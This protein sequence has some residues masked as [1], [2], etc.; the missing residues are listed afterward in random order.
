MI[1]FRSGI[2]LGVILVLGV[3]FWFIIRSFMKREET[4]RST[5]ELTQKK[6]DLQTSRLGMLIKALSSSSKQPQR[7]LTMQPWKTFFLDEAKSLLKAE[8][9]VI[10]LEPKRTKVGKKTF[11]RRGQLPQTVEN[12]LLKATKSHG[13]FWSLPQIRMDYDLIVVSLVVEFAVGFF[14]FTRKSDE[15]FSQEN[16]S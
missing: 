6:L 8:E 14:Q 12:I 5:L 11:S 7:S 10:P 15:A 2:F 9:L 3:L 13:S 4:Y 1:N 16:W